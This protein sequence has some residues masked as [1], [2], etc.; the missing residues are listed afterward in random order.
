MAPK[1]NN[2]LQLIVCSFFAIRCIR[3]GLSAPKKLTSII[4]LHSERTELREKIVNIGVS[5]GRSWKT[6]DLT[7]RDGIV[8]VVSIKLEKYYK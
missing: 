5:I 2:F 8:D 7:S 3:K 4:N 1:K 6:R